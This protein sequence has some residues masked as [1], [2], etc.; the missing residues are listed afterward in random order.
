MFTPDDLA[1][2]EGAGELDMASNLLDLYP[3]PGHVAGVIK[4]ISQQDVTSDLFVRLLEEYRDLRRDGNE[5][6]QK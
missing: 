3:D 4:A 2:A 5:D 1:K 6:P